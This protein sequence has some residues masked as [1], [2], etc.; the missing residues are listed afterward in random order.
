[1]ASPTKITENRRRAKNE[2][3]VKGR[4]KKAR[5]KAAKVSK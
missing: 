1:M 4:N 3:R 5:L 2:K